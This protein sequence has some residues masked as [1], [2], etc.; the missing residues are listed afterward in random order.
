LSGIQRPEI[1][2]RTYDASVAVRLADG[3]TIELNVRGATREEAGA[4]LRYAADC[5]DRASTP[6]PRPPLDDPWKSEAE[7]NLAT[8]A[9]EVSGG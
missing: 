2:Q 5:F 8:A 7:A 3:G 9:S 6:R 1:Q 4:L